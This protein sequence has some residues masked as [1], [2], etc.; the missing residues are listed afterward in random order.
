[1]RQWHY[2][3]FII[4]ATIMQLLLF[5]LCSIHTKVTHYTCRGPHLDW[6]RRLPLCWDN[7]ELCNKLGHC[8]GHHIPPDLSDLRIALTALECCV[9]RRMSR[10]Y[11]IFIARP[12]SHRGTTTT[13]TT[14]IIKMAQNTNSLATTMT[15]STRRWRSGSSGND[16]GSLDNKITQRRRE[17]HKHCVTLVQ[18]RDYEGYLCG[19]LLP[20]VAA[21][22]SYFAICA[23]NVEIASIKDNS[24]L[25]TGW[26][27]QQYR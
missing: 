9:C 15:S 20:S 14:R 2:F 25:V 22:E 8:R 5:L 7:S 23:L 19:L 16:D 26:R 1:M 17:D 27:Q 6:S 21:R 4:I 11:S 13:T 12:C 3:I 18:R 10:Y 24:R